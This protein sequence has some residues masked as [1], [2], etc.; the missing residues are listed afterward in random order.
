M[1]PIYILPLMMVSGHSDDGAMAHSYL[2]KKFA[3]R[4]SAAK[5]FLENGLKPRLRGGEAR[6][7]GVRANHNVAPKASP[8]SHSKSAVISNDPETTVLIRRSDGSFETYHATS[9][10]VNEYD[11][12]VTMP[13]FKARNLASRAHLSEAVDIL[14]AALADSIRMSDVVPAEPNEQVALELCDDYIASGSLA[15]AWG[16]L[17][18]IP[19]YLF[20]LP[21]RDEFRLRLAYVAVRRNGDENWMIQMAAKKLGTP[22]EGEQAEVGQFGTSLRDKKVLTALALGQSGSN[23]ALALA[24]AEEVLRLDPANV[25]AARNAGACWQELKQWSKAIARYQIAL[26]NSHNTAIAYVVRQNQ[27]YCRDHMGQ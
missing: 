3:V 2:Q 21:L 8:K 24:S 27:Q 6:P 20:E 9:D 5:A 13:F 7:R 26:D 11:K 22:E 12:K 17:S 16:V 4:Q 10:P 25:Y 14:E 18:T 19:T 1:H 15:N 23:K